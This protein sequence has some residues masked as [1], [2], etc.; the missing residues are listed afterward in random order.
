[1]K[2]ERR[3]EN[4]DTA[5]KW[6]EGEVARL[7]RE[8]HDREWGIAPKR[9]LKSAVAEYLDHRR[10]TVEY[11]TW[12]TDGNVT[13]HL[14][15]AFKNR[16]VHAI[17]QEQVQK[18]FDDRAGSYAPKTLELYAIHMRTFFAWA[19]R[20]LDKI[21]LLKA[22]VEDVDA[23]TD[24][25][26]E[27]LLKA[28]NTQRE[29]TVI[30]TGL[31]TGA[32]KGELWALEWTDFRADRRS[33][34]IQRQIGWPETVT[35]GLKGKRARTA[36]VLPG[37]M[38]EMEWGTTG[39]VAPGWI[40][41]ESACSDVVERVIRRADLYKPGRATHVLRHT[42]ARLGLEVHEW[43]LHMLMIFLGHTSIKTTERY[44]HFGEETALRLAEE[45]TYK[46]LDPRTTAGE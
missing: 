46:K 15:E 25:E 21:K 13:N 27:A 12:A 37:F 4:K 33:V 14:L 28:C 30:R 24:A 36:L 20:P 40:M 3:T 8:T 2:G 10:S 11:N 42:Y 18:W 6:A 43:S 29:H 44:A 9:P 22:H 39:R 17:S 38:D 7:R 19:G 35:K 41:N 45:R 32:R 1:M 16:D 34:R 5:R 26:I 23:L 31:A